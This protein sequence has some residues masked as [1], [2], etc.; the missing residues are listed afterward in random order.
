MADRWSDIIR[1]AQDAAG[2]ARGRV[3]GGFG[4]QVP[5]DAIMEELAKVVAALAQIS[6]AEKIRLTEEV[7]TLTKRLEALEAKQ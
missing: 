7:L 3:A 2:Y 4:S 1:A 6:Q 5:A